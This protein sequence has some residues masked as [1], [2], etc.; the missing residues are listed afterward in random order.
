MQPVHLNLIGNRTVANFIIFVKPKHCCNNDL[1]GL[2][3]KL[4]TKYAFPLNKRVWHLQGQVPLCLWRGVRGEVFTSCT[5]GLG[6]RSFKHLITPHINFISSPLNLVC[7]AS[8]QSFKIFHGKWNQ[9]NFYGS[10]TQ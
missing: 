10:P 2:P 8:I 9:M 6:V 1:D 5:V 3:N 4:K 7:P